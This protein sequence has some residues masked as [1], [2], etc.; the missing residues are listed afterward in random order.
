MGFLYLVAFAGIPF[1]FPSCSIFVFLFL[2]CL[3]VAAL[4]SALIALAELLT[5]P[6]SACLVAPRGSRRSF[7]GRCR[8]WSFRPSI[9]ANITT[10]NN[11]RTRIVS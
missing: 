6:A 11:P 3:G 10:T 9:S 2:G 8:P 4:I 5:I 7:T 1:F